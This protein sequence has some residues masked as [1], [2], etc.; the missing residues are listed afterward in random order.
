M[1][2]R[3]VSRCR[4]ATVD[5]REQ[6]SAC[7]YDPDGQHVTVRVDRARSAAVGC[8]ERHFAFD[9]AFTARATQSDIYDA[10]GKP[11]VASILAGFNAGILAYG[12]SGSGKSHT[13]FGPPPQ[14]GSGIY[15][16]LCDPVHAGLVPRLMEKL[17]ATMARAS[18]HN[19]Q[20]DFQLTCKFVEIYQDKLVD[21]R[22]P[23]ACS[24]ARAR[25]CS[26]AQ[27]AGMAIRVISTEV[28]VFSAE[29][30]LGALRA[31]LS[32]REVGSTALNSTSS[33]SHAIF[34]LYLRA[35]DGE[36]GEIRRSELH[37]ADLAGSESAASASS[38]KQAAEG[39]M[40]NTSLVHL[41]NVI[42]HLASGRK[43]ESFL[44]RQSKLTRI[45]A[46]VLGGNATCHVVVNHGPSAARATETARSLTFGMA[47]SSIKRGPLVVNRERS[48]PLLRAM[49]EKAGDASSANKAHIRSLES[50][51]AQFALVAR[52]ALE[53]YPAD[54]PGA[55]DL[56]ARFPIMRT[57][58][59]QKSWFAQVR[60][61]FFCLRF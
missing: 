58:R 5:E 61:Y 47:A 38:T 49:I 33:R 34:V 9:R 4:P 35:T 6:S 28:P 27:G 11:L 32:R 42:R 48:A 52:A 41:G 54:S 44:F 60:S 7:S 8:V 57:L 1:V 19:Y 23:A 53:R 2:F 36:S 39:R 46:N 24:G 50:T 17:F 51:I 21:L 16:G 45:L 25:G 3:V 59:L 13:M 10:V 55:R 31:G 29:D 22:A 30:V 56:L 12:Q 37:L 14:R 43:A 26:L 15:D 40:I 18:A 20:L